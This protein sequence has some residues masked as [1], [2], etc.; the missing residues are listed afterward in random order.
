[1]SG[2]ITKL[3]RVCRCDFRMG[4]DYSPEGSHC[5]WVHIHYIEKHVTSFPHCLTV[6][7]SIC[8][9][10]PDGDVDVCVHSLWGLKYTIACSLFCSILFADIIGFTS[11]SLILSAQELV[12]TLNELFGRFDRLA[13]VRSQWQPHQPLH[14]LMFFYCGGFDSWLLTDSRRLCLQEHRCLRI[15]ILGDC[16]YCVSGVPEPQ[17][18]HA[19]CCV[20]MG[21]SMINAIR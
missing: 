18:G 9:M 5:R 17:R 14:R 10:D 3:L 21:L 2:K 13:E 20:D 12:R 4:Q 15:K 1:M 11:L 16:Y 6:T 7:S 19:R 8:W